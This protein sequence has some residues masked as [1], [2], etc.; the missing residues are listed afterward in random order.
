MYEIVYET[1]L[2]PEDDLALKM[3]RASGRNVSESCFSIKLVYRESPTSIILEPAENRSLH[4]VF[5]INKN[6]SKQLILPNN[7]YS[8][9]HWYHSPSLDMRNPPIGKY[10]THYCMCPQYTRGACRSAYFTAPQT[11]PVQPYKFTIQ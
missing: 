10:V 2:S 6:N 8:I 5:F 4:D 1:G 7:S 11:H 9:I 3:T